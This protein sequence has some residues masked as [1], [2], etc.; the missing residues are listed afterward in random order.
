MD[1]QTLRQTCL[2]LMEIAKAVYVS[3]ID[4]QGAP[5]M[6]AMFNLRNKEMFPKIVPVFK[7]HQHDFMILLTTNTSSSKVAQMRANPAVALYYCVPEEWQGL[8]LSGQVDFVHDL[9]VKKSLWQDGW[10]RY[11]PKGYDDPDHT[12]LQLFPQIAKGWN[13]SQ[14][15]KFKIR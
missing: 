5:H 15:F 4:E 2:T 8:M 3:T 14:T 9:K 11:Y 7:D 13:K 10:E 1:E 6:R 12:V